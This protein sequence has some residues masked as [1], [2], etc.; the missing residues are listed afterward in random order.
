MYAAASGN[1]TP[2]IQWQVSTDGGNTYNNIPGATANNLIFTPTQ[3]Q[4]GNMYQAV[5][6]NAVGTVTTTPVTLTIGT[7]IAITLN[8]MSQTVQAGN[9]IPLTAGATGTPNP[10]VVWQYNTGDGNWQTL[11]L[12]TTTTYYLDPQPFENGYEYR[13]LFT[14]AF[15]SVATAPATITL[16]G[17]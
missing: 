13:A 2:S 9:P 8:P 15:G 14:N 1:P 3:D 17:G 16:Q 10:T 4:S 7:P 11:S 5:F 12:A 6:T